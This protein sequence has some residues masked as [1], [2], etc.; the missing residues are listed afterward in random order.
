MSANRPHP[1][2][3]THPIYDLFGSPPC[4]NFLGD[5]VG[6]ISLGDPPEKRREGADEMAAASQAARKTREDILVDA[7]DGTMNF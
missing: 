4:A 7:A 3:P 6:L 1:N 2:T 5:F